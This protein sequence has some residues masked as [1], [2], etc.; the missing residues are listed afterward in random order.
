LVNA[1][2]FLCISS[3]LLSKNDTAITVVIQ[4]NDKFFTLG[5]LNKKRVT[6]YILKAKNGNKRSSQKEGSRQVLFTDISNLAIQKIEIA[7][8]GANKDK[9]SFLMTKFFDAKIIRHGNPNK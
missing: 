5:Y 7:K 8:R 4:I 9:V 2:D 3:A 6:R 1:F